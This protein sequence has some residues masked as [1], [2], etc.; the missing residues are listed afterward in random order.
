MCMY[1]FVKFKK[2]KKKKKSFSKSSLF[3]KIFSLFKML[4]SQRV[5]NVVTYQGL[6]KPKEGQVKQAKMGTSNLPH[7]IIHKTSQSSQR[8]DVLVLLSSPQNKNHYIIPHAS[9]RHHIH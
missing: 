8:H 6:T 3:F 7:P 5:L 4:N 2:K 9:Y 1:I